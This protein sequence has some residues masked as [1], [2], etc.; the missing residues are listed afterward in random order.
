MNNVAPLKA[1]GR[2]VGSSADVTGPKILKAAID[3]FGRRGYTATSVKDLAEAAE[4]T[5]GSIY[6]YYSGKAELF[7]A[8][9][10]EFYDVFYRAFVAALKPHHNFTARIQA[11]LDESEKLH[12]SDPTLPRFAMSLPVELR[13]NPELR[14]S[15]VS[16]YGRFTKLYLEISHEA[17]QRGELPKGLDPQIVAIMLESLFSAGLPQ[18]ARMAGENRFRDVVT[19]FRLLLGKHD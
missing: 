11:L 18:M 13:Y 7:I 6:H 9:A 12:E 14:Q 1:K 10:T 5:V 8:A 2:P 19:A 15:L 4:L 16:L 17:A 3:I